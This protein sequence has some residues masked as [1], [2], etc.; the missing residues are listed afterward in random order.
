MAADLR[1]ELVDADII[2]EKTGRHCWH[3]PSLAK[4]SADQ[5]STQSEK[6][7]HQKGTKKYR[8]LCS[9]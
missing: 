9:E 6:G 5:I 7:Q 8:L 2:A 1:S 4:N 3:F